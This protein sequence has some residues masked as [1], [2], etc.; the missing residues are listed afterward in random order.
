M[1]SDLQCTVTENLELKRLTTL[2]VGGPCKY[3][4][5]P[6]RLADLSEVYT[7]CLTEQ[8]PVLIVGNG[9]NLLPDDKGYDGVVIHAGKRLK[10]FKIVDNIV[11]AEAGVPLPK[12][13]F[14]MARE[15]RSGFEFMAGIP[16]TVGGAIVMNAGCLGHDTAEVLQSVTFLDERGLIQTRS[17]ES[18]GF[19][20]R[21]SM[22]QRIPGLILSASFYAPLAEHPEEVMAK[23]RRAADIRKQKFP[24][25]VATA[26]S[27]F[28]SPPE[29][30]HPGR[31][32][33]EV[34][35]K[36]FQIGS[37]QISPVHAN[38]II[39][40][41]G[42]TSSDVKA[43]MEVMQN[44]VARKLGIVMEPEVLMV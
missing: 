24:I 5:T 38:W 27:T 16:G 31:L 22:L 6:N 39:N 26:G 7:R 33:E 34:G 13:A 36:G 10:T 44:T 9:S 21:E 18:L 20:F 19:S 15:G 30:P 11:Y 4:V 14:S 1:F 17:K 42:A 8:L 41:G 37:A 32:I 25:Q 28:K 2:G 29:G 43:L 3:C 40:L 23:T 35:L 12:L